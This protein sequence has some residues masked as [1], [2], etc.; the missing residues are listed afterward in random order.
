M[1]E[2]TQ[3]PEAT[4]APAGPELT[5]TDLQNI[6]AVLDVSAKRGAFS[7]AEMEAVGATYNKL[8]KFLEAV[9]PK[10]ESAPAEAPAA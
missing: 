9:A 3:T 2:E 7:A 1:S 4:Q 10:Q 8:A 6:R 5:I